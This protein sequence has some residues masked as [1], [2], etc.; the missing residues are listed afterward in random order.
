MN[1]FLMLSAATHAPQNEPVFSDSEAKLL[2]SQLDDVVAL[3]IDVHELHPG[4]PVDTVI[5]ELVEYA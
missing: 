1:D 5:G 4:D 2:A 3:G